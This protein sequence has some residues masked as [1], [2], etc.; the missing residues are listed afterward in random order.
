MT[1]YT[2][3]I[4]DMMFLFE[5]LRNNKNYNEL[6]KYKDVTPDLVKNILDEDQIVNINNFSNEILIDVIPSNPTHKAKTALS[7]KI[8]DFLKSEYNPDLN[9]KVEFKPIPKSIESEPTEHLSNVKNII[10]ISSAKGGV[11]KS[12]ITA[13]IAVTLSNMGFKVGILDADIYGPS[14]HIMF[15]LVGRKPLAVDIKGKSMMQPIESFGIKVLSIGF[16]TKMDQAV[17]WRGPMATKALNQLIFDADWGDLDFMLVDLPPGTGDIHLSIMQKISVNGAVVVST[18]QIV[19]LADARKGVSMYRQEN[20]NIPIL[21]IVE[22]MSYYIPDSK[23]QEKHYIF[24]KDGA[25][26]MA[27]DFDIPFLGEVPILQGIREAGDVGRPGA[28]Q[29]DSNVREIFSEM[30][31]KMV[32]LLLERNKNLPPTEILKIKTMAGCS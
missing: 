27:L 19:A 14:M 2:A 29:D 9:Y 21:G 25:K 1:T 30:T 26:N 7:N 15:D 13:N 4:E 8:I 3:P 18:P 24:G 28:L 5:K 17:I 16:F 12:T 10:A 11:G 6:E 22:N 32:Q 20:I 31:K 23:T